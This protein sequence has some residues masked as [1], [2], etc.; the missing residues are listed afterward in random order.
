MNS[1]PRTIKRSA[2]LDEN[3]DYISKQRRLNA[4]TGIDMNVD[5]DSDGGNCNSVVK[6]DVIDIDGVDVDSSGNAVVVANG[7]G[8]KDSRGSKRH[9]NVNDTTDTTN[10][11]VRKL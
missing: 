10:G 5:V 6:D 7:T 11:K 3:H 4:N 1:N 2:A 9:V 8:A